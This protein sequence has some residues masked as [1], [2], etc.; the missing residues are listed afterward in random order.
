MF[1]NVEGNGAMY[2]K[3]KFKNTNWI[4]MFIFCK[5]P[6]SF[7][8]GITCSVFHWFQ[9]F[10]VPLDAPRKELQFCLNVK[11]NGVT[12]KE[13]KFKNTNWTIMF[14]FCKLAFSSS[15]GITC[16][17]FHWFQK[18]WYHWMCQKKKTKKSFRSLEVIK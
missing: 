8:K 4:V 16:S 2:K 13:F 6:S 14:N 12:Y 1:L 7:S 5:S 15:K 9:K 18:K 3:F 17:F 10:L 11:S